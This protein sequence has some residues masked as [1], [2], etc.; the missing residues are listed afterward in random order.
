MMKKLVLFIVFSAWIL[1]GDALQKLCDWCKC[2]SATGIVKCNDPGIDPFFLHIV[3]N[4]FYW[5]FDCSSSGARQIVPSKLNKFLNLTKVDLKY[6]NK[7]KCSTLKLVPS[8]ISVE[9]DCKATSTQ[10]SAIFS[11]NFE[12]SKTD[13][14]S[15]GVD[16]TSS[17]STILESKT[18]TTVISHSTNLD[19]K[20]TSKSDGTTTHMLETLPFSK[21]DI[22]TT[23]L[24][25]SSGGTA[26]FSS[27]FPQIQQRNEDLI[28]GLGTGLPLLF[29]I[30][31]VIIMYI[32]R[33]KICKRKRNIFRPINHIYRH[34]MFYEM[35]DNQ[36]F[37]GGASRRNRSSSQRGCSRAG[38][39]GVR[40]EQV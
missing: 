17:E 6:A 35:D 16:Y 8:H 5:K 25:S 23:N 21:T 1:P 11:T 4:S 36:S 20:T 19:G 12:T 22:G 32:Q 24:V 38:R 27:S 33:K 3:E 15:T 29:V 18:A 14:I 10:S 34:D 13:R 2:D 7:F 26:E 39:G 37:S 30:S 40:C 9:S 28:I 31:V